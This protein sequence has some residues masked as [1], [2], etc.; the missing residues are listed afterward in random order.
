MVND[1]NGQIFRGADEVRNRWEEYFE[2]V[3]NLEDVREANVNKVGGG[4][5]CGRVE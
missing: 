4:C 5:L 1:K 3:L 2:Y